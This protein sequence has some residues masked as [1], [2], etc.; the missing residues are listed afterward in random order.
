[1]GFGI[2]YDWEAEGTDSDG[3]DFAEQKRIVKSRRKIPVTRRPSPQTGIGCKMVRN[4]G[5]T[6]CA[7]AELSSGVRSI[8][9]Y[10][11]APTIKCHGSFI[12]DDDGNRPNAT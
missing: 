10:I 4:T 2:K 8:S 6:N 3:R 9:Q 7:M 11:P 12:G 5:L 1:M